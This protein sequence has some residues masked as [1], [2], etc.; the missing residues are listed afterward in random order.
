MRYTVSA[1]NRMYIMY[2]HNIVHTYG[3]AF[4]ICI[5]DDKHVS[6]INK[7]ALFRDYPSTGIL[8]EVNLRY[9]VEPLS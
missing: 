6:C 7:Q 8:S 2:I 4:S 9:K 3:G 5:R 1:G